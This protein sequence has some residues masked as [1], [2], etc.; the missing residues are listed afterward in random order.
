MYTQTVQTPYPRVHTFYK[1][2]Y[3]VDFLQVW[4]LSPDLPAPPPPPP[5]SPLL[6]FF[7]LCVARA[8]ESSP[9]TRHHT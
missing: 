8:L 2:K 5:L 4:F 6:P 9:V 1:I 3:L 7:L